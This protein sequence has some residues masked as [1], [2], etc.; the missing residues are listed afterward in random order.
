MTTPVRRVLV[1]A[2]VVKPRLGGLR[3]YTRD[4]VGALHDRGDLAL[5]VATSRPE[6]FTHAPN[7]DIV[8]LPRATRGFTA[9]SAWRE[10]ALARLARRTGAD[11]VL[12]PYPEMT[13]RPLPVPS[14]MVVHDVRAIVAPRY[15][16]R[17]RRVR[18]LL[19]LPPACRAATHVVC[20]S[21]FTRLSL[22]ACV[23]LDQSRVTVIA[24]AASRHVT[25][26]AAPARAAGTPERPF[27]LYVGSLMPH[28]NVDTLVR[29]FGL[30]GVEHDLVLVGPAS[31]AER[32]HLGRVIDEAGS[33]RRVRHAGWLGDGEL[34]ALYR[35]ASAVAI[36]SIHEGFGL[37]VVE[38]MQLG[39]AVVASDIPAFREVGGPHVTLVGR[40]LDPVAWRDALAALDVDPAA[41]AAAAEWASRATWDSVA[42]QFVKLFDE[43]GSR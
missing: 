37:P 15:D 33:G 23:R 34:G 22:D 9:R 5:T 42:G 8:E 28:K 1:D 38:A 32:E 4:R 24:E 21:E 26:P 43:V 19:A 31:S 25:A 18:F 39:V 35:H 6:E 17:G 10:L 29:A 3:T 14:V 40:P 12:V 41:L 36:P 13:V 16:T 7:A 2:A 11:I 27:V 20:V 30:D